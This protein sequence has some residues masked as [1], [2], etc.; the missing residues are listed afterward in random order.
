VVTR[1]LRV[2]ALLAGALYGAN[3]LA[4]SFPV[5]P[6]RLI[7]RAPPGGADDLHARILSQHL[8]KVLGQPVVL[9][10]RPGAGG[11]VAWEFTAK[12]PPDGYTLLLAASGLAGIQSLRPDMPVDPWKDFAWVSQIATFPLIFTVHPALP[13]KNLKELIALARKRPGQL[14]YGS[15]G[16]GATPHIAAEYFRAAAKIELNHIPFKGAS[17]MYLDLMAGRIE[18]GTSVLGSAIGFVKS[19]KV[20]ALAV[21]SATRS[22]V[23]PDVP[24]V[25]EAAGLPGFE[26]TPFYAIVTQGQ[27]PRDLVEQ[28]SAAIGRVMAIPEFREAIIAAGS[29]PAANTPEQMLALAKRAA[30]QIAKIVQASGIKGTD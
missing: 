1:A 9:D 8:G 28:L 13:V 3:A 15:S 5:K 7:V 19:G 14:N 12:S 6:L 16:I 22:T 27:T 29:E 17:P 11:L 2:G 18:I 25:A 4:Q 21:T 10:Y 20:R 23:L 26:F 24:T 30:A